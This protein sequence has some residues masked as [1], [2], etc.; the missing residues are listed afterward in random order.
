MTD[1]WR[2]ACN[3]KVEQKHSDSMRDSYRVMNQVG[4]LFP[5]LTSSVNVIGRYYLSSSQYIR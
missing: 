5:Q 1:L 2:A 3:L 4:L